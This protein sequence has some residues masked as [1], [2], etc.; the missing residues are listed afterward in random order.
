VRAAHR[1]CDAYLAALNGFCVQ[2]GELYLGTKWLGQKLR[3]LGRDD[4]VER[5]REALYLPGRAGEAAEYGARVSSW[6]DEVVDGVGL[7]ADPVLVCTPADGVETWR[8]NGRVLVHRHGLRGVQLTGDPGAS[9]ASWTGRRAEVT[10]EQLALIDEGLV[11]L[12]A[13]EDQ[14]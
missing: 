10:A 12:S 3:R 13:R 6:L 11:W 9:P 5:Y 8:A 7:P 14:A 2:S 4:L 1:W